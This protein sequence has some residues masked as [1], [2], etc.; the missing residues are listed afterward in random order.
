MDFQVQPLVTPPQPPPA[1]TLGNVVLVKDTE[2]LFCFEFAPFLEGV[3]LKCSFIDHISLF[4][5]ASKYP[6][7][8]T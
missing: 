2:V 6:F 4:I 5:T 1:K 3:Q 8:P 7:R